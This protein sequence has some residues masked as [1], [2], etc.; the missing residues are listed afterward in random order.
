MHDYDPEWDYET[1]ERPASRYIDAAEAYARDRLAP[2]LG[3]NTPTLF[4]V[5]EGNFDGAVAKYVAGTSANPVIGIDHEAHVELSE[6]PFRDMG[7]E[8][9]A[10]IAHEMAH[11]YLE[12]RGVDPEDH[13]EDAIEAFARGFA[14]AL[15][16]DPAPLDEAHAG[17]DNDGTVPVGRP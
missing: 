15:E 8:L 16:T 2:A 14:D 7:E 5:E 4:F 17:L 11:A 6:Q 9:L 12:T 13:D 10:S 1:V 3:L